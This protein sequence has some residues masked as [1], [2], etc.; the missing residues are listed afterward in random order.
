MNHYEEEDDWSPP[1]NT[2]H[3]FKKQT[4]KYLGNITDDE[5]DELEYEDEFDQF[6]RLKRRGKR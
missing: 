1:K 2:K 3:L 6:E 5:F 4:K